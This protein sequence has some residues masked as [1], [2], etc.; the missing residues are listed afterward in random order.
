[1]QQGNPHGGTRKLTVWYDGACPLC[2]R[3]I[4]VLKRLDR[5]RAIEFIDAS[6]GQPESCPV[7][8]AD[9]LA[10]FHARDGDRLLSGAAAFAAAFRRIPLL[11]P[12][13]ELARL[14][15]LDRAFEGLYLLFLRVRP[16]IQRWVAK[17]D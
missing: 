17:L 14:P 5:R 4:K 7:S 8:Q 11:R 12:V 15:L 1:M 10:R 3:E 9:L 16:R 2:S 13:G 6:E